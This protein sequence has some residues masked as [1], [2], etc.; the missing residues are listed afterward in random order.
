MHSKRH[1]SGK[2]IGENKHFPGTLPQAGGSKGITEINGKELES[3]F[4]PYFIH[5][6]FISWY[7]QTWEMS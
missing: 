5:E 7:V 6:G 2:N 4:Q 3:S 1:F